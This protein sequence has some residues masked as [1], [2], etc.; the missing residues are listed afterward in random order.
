M[1]DTHSIPVFQSIRPAATN[2]VVDSGKGETR[3][4][5]LVATM[6]EA[7]ERYCGEN[8]L[9]DRIALKDID[10]IE[11]LVSYPSLPFRRPL[12]DNLEVTAVKRYPDMKLFYTPS[13]LISYANTNPRKELSRYPWGT[14]GL[15]AHTSIESAVLSGLLEV[16]ERDAISSMFFGASDITFR[17]VDVGFIPEELQVLAS[18]IVESPYELMILEIRT[19]FD[20]SVFA[21]YH[22]DK[23]LYPGGIGY[24]THP[25]RSIGLKHALLEAAQSR[26]L[27]IAG[28]RD[29]LRFLINDTYMLDSLFSLTPEQFDDSSDDKIEY[30]SDEETLLYC[31][32]KLG[33]I[34]VDIY[35]C[36]LRVE[37]SPP[38][39]IVKVIAPGLRLLR[40][41]TAM[42]GIPL[43]PA[44]EIFA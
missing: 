21:V 35:F 11:D 31:V 13:E 24:G 30:L 20:M 44:M 22:T 25:C 12:D 41:G 5:A 1:L 29:D 8:Y 16:M 27:R 39:K 18:K 26:V 23:Y 10:S 6:A 19:R 34:N 43:A 2:L 40:Q 32:E 14:T 28:S 38:L 15:G 42:T 36:D 3:D 17:R 9:N 33:S 7:I 4:E 37:P